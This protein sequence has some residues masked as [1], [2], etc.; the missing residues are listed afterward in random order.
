M[1]KILIIDMEIG[2]AFYQREIETL[3][4][5]GLYKI[6][7]VT[8]LEKVAFVFTLFTP[9][10]IIMDTP[11]PP[12]EF[13]MEETQEGMNTGVAFYHKYIEPKNIPT[14][15][16][17]FRYEIINM[18]WGTGVIDKIRKEFGYHLTKI[19]NEYFKDKG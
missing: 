14:I 2:Q 16:W 15:I 11:F 18:D 1:K 9:D 8:E 6:G 13:T 3:K 5:S 4:E 10:L 12:G 17:T 19:I 7:W